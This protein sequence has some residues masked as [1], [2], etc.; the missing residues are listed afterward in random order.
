MKRISVLFLLIGLV[1]LALSHSLFAQ[2]VTVRYGSWGDVNTQEAEKAIIA[3]FERLNPDIKVEFEPATYGDYTRVMITKLAAGT[4]PDVLNIADIPNWAGFGMLIE[5]DAL[6]E[7]DDSF[8]VDD[9]FPPVINQARFDGLRVGQGP[10][11]GIPLNAGFGWILFYNKEMFDEYGI[12]YPDGTWTWDRLI[13]EGLKFNEDRD[14]DGV[15]DQYGFFIANIW[16]HWFID[17]MFRVFGTT[18]WSE[19]AKSCNAGTEIGLQTIQFIS[20]LANK[21]HVMPKFAERTEELTFEYGNIAMEMHHSYKIPVFTSRVSFEWDMAPMPLGPS[22]FNGAAIWGH[23]L[24]INAKCD[25]DKKDT[26]WRLIKFLTSK[27]VQIMRLGLNTPPS[28]RSVTQSEEFK[29]IQVPANMQLIIDSLENGYV[30][31][32]GPRTNEAWEMLHGAFDKVVLAG[33]PAE[34]YIP[35]A[36]KKVDKVLTRED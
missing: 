5:L 32:L 33:K 34:N 16:D 36:V 30:Y 20:D 19:D 15:L 12:S 3:E 22:G 14:G 25:E 28:R 26:A 13:E 17:N 9:F 27:E 35:R 10:Q 18:L 24:G 23:P 7:A 11:Y 8:D 1:S 2:E 31:P 4:A 29:S 21:H 6:I